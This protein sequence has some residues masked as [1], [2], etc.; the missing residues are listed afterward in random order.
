MIESFCFAVREV[1]EFT[2]RLGHE[3]STVNGDR[4]SNAT[5]GVLEMKHEYMNIIR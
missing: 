3:D 2:Y 5:N 4:W 1:L